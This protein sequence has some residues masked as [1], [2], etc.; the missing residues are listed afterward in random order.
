MG[1]MMATAA[2]LVMS[3]VSS[4]VMPYSSG[5]I[6]ERPELGVVSAA[7]SGSSVVR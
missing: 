7:P 3:S 1:N 2:L 4:A 6:T 5:T